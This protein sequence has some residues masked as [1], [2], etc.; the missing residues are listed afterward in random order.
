MKRFVLQ[1]TALTFLLLPQAYAAEGDTAKAALEGK[2]ITGTV[3]MTQT[4]SGIIHIVVDAKGVPPGPHG[5]H[6]HETGKCNAADGFES[7]GGHLARGLQHGLHVE[8][9]PHPGDLPNVHVQ[10]DGVLQ[11]EFFTRDF[12]LGSDGEQRLAD[13]DGS[14]IVLHA[15]PDDYKSQPSGKSGDRIACG[16]INE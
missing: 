14:A 7:A 4:S 9:G 8:A 1:V 15:G 5:I 10:E 13:D 3:T 2:G 11:A 6:I 12:A 16:V